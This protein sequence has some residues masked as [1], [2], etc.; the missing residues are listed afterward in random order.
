MQKRLD[1]SLSFTIMESVRKGKGLTADME[2]AMIEY[3]VPVWY[4]E[5]C[6]KIKYMFPKAHAAAYVL[7]AMRIANFKVFHPK[8]FYAAVLSV[9]YNDENIR[10]LNLEPKELKAKIKEYD[11]EIK[12]LNNKEPNK[13]NRMK[14]TMGAMKLVLEAKVRGV[15][16]GPVSIENSHA[17]KYIIKDGVLIP[18][19]VGIEGLGLNAAELIHEEFQK[20]PFK[21][22]EDMKVRGI[23]PSVMDKLRDFNCLEKIEDVQY[24][25]F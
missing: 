10:E 16:F 8:E 20:E 25:L 5:S 18:P 11:A 4:L 24:Y 3:E 15:E 19:F 14:R 22:T 12:V 7:S 6:K 9:R 1:P 21:S 2:S 23:K 17:S 13:A